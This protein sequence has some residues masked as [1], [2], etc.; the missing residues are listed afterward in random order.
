MSEPGK[1]D[2]ELDKLTDIYTLLRNDAK[3]IITDLRGGVRMWREAAGASA[4][5]AGFIF[6][7]V[8]TSYR[9][10]SPGNSFEAWAFI[11]GATIVGFI[12]LGISLLGFRKYFQLSKKY[13]PLF[14]RA[15][16]L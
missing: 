12:M 3:S 8:L 15:E 11:I 2:E 9:I 5:S 16:R 10:H 6:L 1:D 4:S 13:A 14:D 7:L